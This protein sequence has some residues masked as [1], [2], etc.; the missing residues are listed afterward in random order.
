MSGSSSTSTVA[1]YLIPIFLGYRIWLA[2]RMPITDCDEVYNYWEPLHY[3]LYGNGFQTWEYSNEYALRT[4]AYLM[5]LVGISR[6]YQQLIPFLPTWWWPLLSSQT[7]NIAGAVGAIGDTTNGDTHNKVALFILLRATLALVMALG[8]ISFCK[9][10]VNHNGND[11]DNKGSSSTTNLLIG[12]V[13]GSLLLSSAGMAHSAGALLPS[14][15]LMAIWLFAASAFLRRH[16]KLF[17]TLAITATLA[18]G[19]PFGV[20]MFV[21]LGFTILM[22]ERSHIILFLFNILMTTLAVQGIVMYIDQQQYSDWASPTLNIFMYNTK[23]GGDELYGIEPISYY[24][25][26][27]ILNFN[28][29]AVFGIISGMPLLLLSFL[30]K[31]GSGSSSDLLIILL[32]MYI[33][34]GVVVPRPHKEE[35]FLFPI[36]PCLCLGAAMLSVNFVRLVKPNWSSK[37]SLMVLAIMWLPAV[38]ISISRTLGLSKYYAAPLHVYSHLQYL[39]D[40]TDSTI[41]TC[42]E[43]YRFPSSFYLPASITKFG[44]V[45]SS[46][47]GQLP[48]S[49]VPGVGSGKPSSKKQT[50]N[51]FNDQNLPEPGSLTALDDCDYL[52]DLWTSTDCRENDSIWKPIA[53]E[54]FLNADQTSSTLHRALYL[55]YLHEQETIRGG[56]EYVD[57][58]LYQRQE[59]GSK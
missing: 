10:I 36:Y 29:V 18:I 3:L 2:N 52:V 7:N 40:I 53:H 32:P 51:H 23:A 28:Y 19:W 27:L 20:L 6:I 11:S 13:T 24:M 39:P 56:V 41:C 21:P 25:K 33:W 58:I 48:Q 26:N 47:E 50:P 46:F 16:H 12:I 17:A 45:Q 38:V 57:Y 42:G 35:R 49:F 1:S 31:K 5:P 22:R 55:P 37:N 43:W 8:E 59:E 44:F 4:Y 15:T 14:S 34:L 9:A 54:S 30:K